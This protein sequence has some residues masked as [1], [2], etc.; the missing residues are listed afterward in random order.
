[1]TSRPVFLLCALILATAP[2]RADPPVASY[3]FPAGG[4]RGQTVKVRAGGLYLHDRCGWEMLGPGLTTSKQLVRTSTRWF[5][6]PL[7]PLP[8][9]QQAENYPRDLL[10]EVTIARDAPLGPRRGRVWTAEGAHAGL[11][12][13][14]G[15]LPE[16]VEV[17]TD[18]DPVPVEV[19]LPVTINGRI[20]PREDIDIWS[21]RARKGQV[22]TCEVYAARIGSP[23]DSRL[24]VRGP[25]GKVVAENDDARGTDSLLHFTAPVNGLYQV[26]IHDSQRGGSQQHV[27]RLTI[28]ADPYITHLYP[29]GGRQGTRVRFHLRGGNVPAQPVELLLPPGGRGV[30]MQPFTVGGRKT[31]EVRVDVDDL[32]E[33]LQLEPAGAAPPLVELP[34]LLNSR[35]GRPGEA[36]C[37]RAQGKKGARW[38]LQLRAA[39]LGS[40]LRGVIEVLDDGGKVLAQARGNT[41][42]LDPELLFNVPRDGYYTI[43]VRDFFRTRGGPAFAYRLRA[44][45]AEPDFRLELSSAAHTLVRGQKANLRVR[46]VRLGG[47]NVPVALTVKGLPAGVTVAVVKARPG[48]PF[49][50]LAF[51]AAASAAIGTSRIQISGTATLAGQAVSRLATLESVDDVL[52]AVALRAPFKVVG[53]YDLRLAP[54]GTVFRKRFKIERNGYAGPLEVS[55]ADKQARHLQGVTGPRLTVPA[56]ASEFEYPVTLPP[57]ME[58]GRTS[59]ACVMVVGQVKE[60]DALHTVSYTSQAQNDQI[61]AVVE[62]GRL[63]LETGRS[64]LAVRPGTTA[65]LPVSVRRGK[66]LN[67]PVKVELIVPAHIGGVSARP[68]TLATDATRGTLVLTFADRPGPF[69]QPL[70]V[71]ATLTTPAGPVLAEAKVELVQAD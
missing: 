19:T 33:V 49:V 68:L 61:I 20:F 59:R 65:A 66:G 18:G 13:V 1:M 5:E 34:C 43:R 36:S 35:V 70:V 56:D 2:L 7:L 46:V 22:I 62:T 57:W 21:F 6:G 53:S 31:N 41:A 51:S 63:G 4:Q 42:L 12:F 38:Q 67:G 48:Q 11:T 52:L 45:A 37:F 14:V 30:R 32:P 40:P 39:V 26:H 10:G 23:L 25:D 64:S 15:D 24:V 27:Y 50:D 71:R 58:T 55:L 54:R 3:L 28:T 69:N 8:A 17:E 60:G 47:C 29:L 44:T 9:S 16:V